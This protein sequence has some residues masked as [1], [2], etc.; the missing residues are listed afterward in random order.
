MNEYDYVR[1]PHL[2]EDQIA[3]ISF[4]MALYDVLEKFL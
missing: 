2:Y 3:R 1:N 4:F